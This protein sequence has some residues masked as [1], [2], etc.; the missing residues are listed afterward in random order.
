MVPDDYWPRGNIWGIM[1]RSFVWANDAGCDQP[2]LVVAVVVPVAVVACAVAVVIAVVVIA[3]VVV[4]A[5]AWRARQ[6]QD[7]NRRCV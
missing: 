2:G 5:D 6:K 7:M 3:G 1:I 4:V